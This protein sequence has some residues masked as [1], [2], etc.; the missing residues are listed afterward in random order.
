MSFSASELTPTELYRTSSYE[1][2]D[3]VIKNGTPT[4]NNSLK[5]TIASTSSGFIGAFIHSQ[6]V[7]KAIA[8]NNNIESVKLSLGTMVLSKYT[9]ELYKDHMQNNMPNITDTFA[10]TNG[11][12]HP[13]LMGKLIKQSFTQY[14]PF[15]TKVDFK[16]TVEITFKKGA[17]SIGSLVTDIGTFNL[18]VY[19]VRDTGFIEQIYFP[20]IRNYKGDSSSQGYY[21]SV[22]QGAIDEVYLL[23]DKN[24]TITRNAEL[25]I[26]NTTYREID[27]SIA[28]NK[29]GYKYAN[30]FNSLHPISYG[31]N[32]LNIKFSKLIEM[33]GRCISVQFPLKTLSSY[34]FSVIGYI[35]FDG[36][37]FMD[38]YTLKVKPQCCCE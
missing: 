31:E 17:T 11:S 36:Q 24:A 29:L 37:I 9:I 23:F 34:E 14:Y 16:Y 12:L 38:K 13:I 33:T 30:I 32:G 1:Y 28:S 19:Y 27:K 10:A 22:T 35:Y 6:F 7:S 21:G 26:D 5:F 2:T 25:L 8:A 3:V 20:I 18:I 15:P 4:S